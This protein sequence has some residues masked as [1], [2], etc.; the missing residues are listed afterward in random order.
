MTKNLPVIS[1]VGR[2]NVGKSSLFNRVI[3][4]RHA[5]VEKQEGTTRDRIEKPLKVKGK[6]FILADTG[7]FFPQRKDQMQV[8]IK[9]QIVKAVLS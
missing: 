4:K 7:G 1:I 9:S 8:L 3:G 2:P 5:V 6:N